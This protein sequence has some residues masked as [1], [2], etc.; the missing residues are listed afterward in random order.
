ML[1]VQ[2]NLVIYKGDTFSFSFR[3]RDRTST[4]ELGNYVDLTGAT[5]KSQIRLTADS[6]S[7]I[8]EFDVTIPNQSVAANKGRV[9]LYLSP[10]TT[11]SSTFVNGS[12]DAQ[13]TFPDGTIRTYLHGTVTV[14]KEV[15]R[16]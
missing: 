5:G 11:G 4:G 13:I 14:M 7:V 2:R 15:T 10:E 9:N 1:P 6:A 8:A 12:W 16:A 3:L